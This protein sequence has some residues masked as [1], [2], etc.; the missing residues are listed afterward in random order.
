MQLMGGQAAYYLMEGDFV[1]R[2]VLL[3]VT[4]C[5]WGAVLVINTAAAFT[6]SSVG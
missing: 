4:C 3:Y 6:C 5:V 1:L 2:V